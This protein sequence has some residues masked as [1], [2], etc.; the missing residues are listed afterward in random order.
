MESSREIQLI[1]INPTQLTPDKAVLLEIL[2]NDTLQKNEV[3][4]KS[5]VNYIISMPGSEQ[6]TVQLT[7]DILLNLK[8][9][10]G[11][12]KKYRIEPHCYVLEGM[13]EKRGGAQNVGIPNILGTLTCNKTENQGML[14]VSDITKN[15][16]RLLKI[17]A[18]QI[19]ASYLDKK[20]EIKNMNEVQQL[21]SSKLSILQTYSP[22]KSK[23]IIRK[24]QT[25]DKDGLSSYSEGAIESYT[26]MKKFKGQPLSKL[27]NEEENPPLTNNERIQLSLALLRELYRL[28][29]HYG[30]VHCDIKPENIIVD[31]DRKNQTIAIHFVDFDSAKSKHFQGEVSFTPSYASPELIIDYHQQR[32]PK[33]Q[34]LVD[35]RSDIW[36]MGL[37]LAEVWR[38]KQRP[39]NW[40]QNLN[41]ASLLTHQAMPTFD[42]TGLDIFRD[43]KN[44]NINT[45]HFDNP[46]TKKLYNAMGIQS[47]NIDFEN[48]LSTIQKMVEPDKNNRMSDIQLA[49][50]EFEKMKLTFLFPFSSET[51]KTS[52]QDQF[53]NDLKNQEQKLTNLKA[54]LKQIEDQ[55]E[56]I[57]LQLD[58]LSMP[59]EKQKNYAKIEEINLFIGTLENQ[60][61]L[62]YFYN[63]CISFISE[64]NGINFFLR[65]FL[66]GNSFCINLS[67]KETK[68][69]EKEFYYL[70]ENI[71]RIIE[72]EDPEKKYFFIKEIKEALSLNSFNTCKTLEEMLTISTAILDKFSSLEYQKQILIFKLNMLLQLV[73]RLSSPDYTKNTNLT[74][75]KINFK[76]NPALIELLDNTSILLG[77]MNKKKDQLYTLD[78][79]EYFNKKLSRQLNILEDYS[80]NIMGVIHS[81]I[82]L[83]HQDMNAEYLSGTTLD[84]VKNFEII[85]HLLT[86]NHP[87]TRAEDLTN[88]IK[89]AILDYMKKTSETQ[90]ISSDRLMDLVNMVSIVT[91]NNI[92]NDTELINNIRTYY[93]KMKTGFLGRSTLQ[94]NIEAA[95]DN[96]NQN[97]K[98]LLSQSPGF[99]TNSLSLTLGPP[100][101]DQHI[102]SPNIRLYK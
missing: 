30:I 39:N 73:E 37:V 102:H 25:Q 9:K 1:Q 41:E 100:T 75:I 28:H 88:R 97:Y 98:Y 36:Q 42:E 52:L 45:V 62:L 11:R 68:K 46:F 76:S 12:D 77:K 71:N 94:T 24:K 60:I 16:N 6:I 90:L 101:N 5:Y 43:I 18:H 50:D 66:G 87:N 33:H 96:Y 63:S 29:H 89:M 21:I 32:N 67:P 35:Q 56:S 82:M 95:I 61:E 99:F 59:I 78:D 2:I 14:Y 53:K 7:H 55:N 84:Y 72:N 64:A 26:K 57:D 79:I 54:K 83:Q 49:I 85:L 48:I 27:L 34:S 3:L 69:M 70:F 19:D 13:E 10:I 8:E 4:L 74:S 38:S 17:N 80:N 31:F 40:Y 65:K 44:V 51:K 58:E 22:L 93:P 91:D 20:G 15:K 86:L 47:E 81:D 92:E 23:S